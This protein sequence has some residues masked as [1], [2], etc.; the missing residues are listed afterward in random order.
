MGSF[1]EDVERQDMSER[2]KN[3]KHV[4]WSKDQAGEI[5]AG[6]QDVLSG[7]SI[8]AELR[9]V[10]T[11]DENGRHTVWLAVVEP[12]GGQGE[13]PLP[14]QTLVAYNFGR[15]CPPCCYPYTNPLCY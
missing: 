13:A 10:K 5:L 4:A 15:P 11:I 3:W 14:E 12:G 7:A 8:N 1:A 2:S 6:L 9:V